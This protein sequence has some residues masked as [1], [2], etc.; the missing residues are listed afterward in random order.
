M[1]GYRLERAYYHSKSAGGCCPYDQRV[2]IDGRRITAELAELLTYLTTTLP[3]QKACEMLER[4]LKRK[5]STTTTWRLTQDVGAAAAADEQADADRVVNGETIKP[6]VIPQTLIVEVDA[7][8]VNFRDHGWSD[9]KLGRCL[10]PSSEGTQG[11]AGGYSSRFVACK[12]EAAAF[13]PHAAALARRCGALAADQVQLLADGGKWIW[14]HLLPLLPKATHQTLDW[15]HLSSHVGQAAKS[16]H[17]EQT[18]EARAY[19]AR[20]ENLLWNGKF[21]VLL[22]QL[23]SHAKRSKHPTCREALRQF[24]G[25]IENNQ[26]RVNYSMTRTLNLPIGS[27]AIE[28]G[29]KQHIGQRFKGPG[30]RWSNDGCQH[31]LSLRSLVL[32][33]RFDQFWHARKHPLIQP[34]T[35][36]PNTTD[37][38][39]AN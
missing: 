21:G 27:G 22:G 1:G 18:T 37:T 39:R 12:A 36:R 33:N 31:L 10:W 6:A 19:I 13:A 7:A 4:C 2:G 26:T 35:A 16:L 5:V 25:Y 30:M 11:R 32:S 38:K 28:S 9:V 20:C 14:D 8:M 29:C 23:R 24:I 34:L 15:Y 17:G 3:F